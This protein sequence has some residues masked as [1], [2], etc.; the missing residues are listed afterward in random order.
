MT[1]TMIDD[2][3]V[4]QAGGMRRRRRRRHLRSAH[5]RAGGGSRAPAA[6]K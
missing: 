2:L 4:R 3:C 6:R 5:G 1:V